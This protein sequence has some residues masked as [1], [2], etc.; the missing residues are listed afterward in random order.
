MKKIPKLGINMALVIHFGLT[1]KGSNTNVL[2]N[3]SLPLLVSTRVLSFK[4]SLLSSL[5]L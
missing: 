3:K 2:P 4:T 5:E 1:H